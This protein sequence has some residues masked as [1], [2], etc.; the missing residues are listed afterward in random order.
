MEEVAGLALGQ[1]GLFFGLFFIQALLSYHKLVFHSRPVFFFFYH[2]TSFW[3]VGGGSLP[4]SIFVAF[5]DGSPTHAGA[6]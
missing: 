6:I 4:T 3:G 5:T 2:W 1:Q